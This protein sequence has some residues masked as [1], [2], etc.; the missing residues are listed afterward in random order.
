MK[1]IQEFQKLYFSGDTSNKSTQKMTLELPRRSHKSLMIH[2]LACD[3]G[4]KSKCIGKMNFVDLAGNSFT[5]PLDPILVS[6]VRQLT[7]LYLSGYENARRNSID[8]S[9]FIEGTQINKS[10][11][12]FVNIINAVNANETRVPY[13]ESK[14][15]RVLQDCLGGNNH[16]SMIV[17]LVSWLLILIIVFQFSD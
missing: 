1:T 16:I 6:C 8:G 13:R 9:S 3:E 5:F 17:C 7:I 2:I 4:G 10:L 14:L 11:N 12:A 15:A